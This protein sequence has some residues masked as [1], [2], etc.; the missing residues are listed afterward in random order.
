MEM[1]MVQISGIVVL[2]LVVISL[3]VL[4]CSREQAPAPAQAP[5]P[6]ST[7]QTP[8]PAGT[9]PAPAPAGTVPAPAPAGTASQNSNQIQVG[10]TGEQV[11]QIMGAPGQIKQK[12]AIIE[13]KYYGPQGK[14]EV[15]LQ[16]NKVTFVE[17]H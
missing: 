3:M 14:V 8:A 17:R 10:M 7:V 5:P 1:K 4:G 16:N 12:G 13:W 6:A 9:V 15:K 2:M 11:Q